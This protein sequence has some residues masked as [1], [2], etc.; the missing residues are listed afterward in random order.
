[1][2]KRNVLMTGL[3]IVL[4]FLYNTAAIAVTGL[5]GSFGL[6]GRV[7][8]ELGHK[9]SGHAVLVQPDG[10]IVVAGSSA[11]GSNLNFSLL[12]FNPNG[13][14]DPTFNG[15]GSVITSLS[16][17]D[18]EALALALLADGRIIAAGYSHNGKDRDFAIVCYRQDGSLDRSFGDRGV[19]LTAIGNG[20]EEITAVAVGGANTITVAGS[21]EGTAGRILVAAR[22]FA[23]GNLDSGFGEHGMS[24]IGVGEDAS[25]EGVVERSDGTLVLSGSTLHLQKSSVLLVGLDRYGTLNPDFGTKGVTVASGNFAASEGYGLAIDGQGMIY[26]AGAVGLPGKRDSALFRFTAQGESDTGFGK[27]GVA[28]TRVSAEDD[29]LYDVDA[30]EREVAAGGFTTDA[31]TRQSLLLSYSLEAKMIAASGQQ[32][33]ISVD[34]EADEVVPVQEVKV[35]GNTRL[36]IR[37]LQMW[38]SDVRIQD[39]RLSDSLTNPSAFIQ[40]KKSFPSAFFMAYPGERAAQH[41]PADDTTGD[42]LLAF[43][44]EQVGNFFLPQALAVTAASS[45]A[46]EQEPFA[47]PKIFTTTFSEGESVSF[48]LTSD[49]D[50]NILVVGTADGSDASSMVAARFSAEDMVDRISDNPGRRNKHITTHT[51]TSITQTSITTGGEIDTAFGKEVVRRGVVFSLQSGPVYAGKISA[52]GRQTAATGETGVDALIALLLPNAVAAQTSTNQ[53]QS[54][55]ALQANT[56]AVSQFINAGNIESGLGTGAFVAQ[57]DHL[58]PGTIYYLRSYALTANGEVY[59]GNQVT[60]KTA[61]ACFIA[62]ASFGSFLHPAVTILRDFRDN[63]LDQYAAGRWLVESYYSFSPPIA[64]MIAESVALRWLVRVFLLPV[65]GFSWLVL[66]VGLAGVACCTVATAAVLWLLAGRWHRLWSNVRTVTF[67]EE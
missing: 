44:A 53:P 17:G 21:T 33:A 2:L 32:A 59:Y 23:N 54:T 43:V 29:V 30:G 7:A 24:L 10:K 16:D 57:I 58:L 47:T 65:V 60:A 9:N 64:E 50:G 61:D 67:K 22:Y 52:N 42:R 20:N 41:F 38:N 3:W 19:V 11:T 37:Q 27:Q 18:D 14:L 1:M 48:A 5:D 12:R 28:I 55:T 34:Y 6:N 25:A 13:T 15:D 63:V 36:Q 40:P 66:K 4:G 62:T 49:S 35:N 31:G 45:N 51:P 46:S 8:V 56:I 26:V 39:L